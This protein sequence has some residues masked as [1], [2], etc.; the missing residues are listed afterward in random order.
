MK[1]LEIMNN[2]RENAIDSRE[3]YYKFLNDAIEEFDKLYDEIFDKYGCDDGLTLL[4]NKELERLRKNVRDYD[5]LLDDYVL[6]YYKE[7]LDLV[8]YYYFRIT[9]ENES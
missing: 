2:M 3:N 6:T 9:L 5:S 8:K 1:S 4:F 7:L